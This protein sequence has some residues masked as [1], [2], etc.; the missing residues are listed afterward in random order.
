[1]QNVGRARGPVPAGLPIEVEAV[2]R[3]ADGA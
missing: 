3:A 1:M 2:A